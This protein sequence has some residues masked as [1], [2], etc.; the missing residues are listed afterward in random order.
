MTGTGTV[1]VIVQ[2]VNDH[3]PEFKRQA[4]RATIAEN[5]PSGTWVLTPVA[6]DKDAG[7]NAKIRYSLLGD[8]VDRFKINQDTG[9]ISTA[10]SLDREDT[11]TYHLTLI[12]QD[13]SPTEPRASTVNLTIEVTDE[14]DNSPTF[15]SSKFEIY[16]SDKTKVNQFVF[17][18]YAKDTDSGRNSQVAYRLVGEHSRF[19]R[20]N[21]ETG[22]IKVVQDLIKASTSV[23]NLEVEASDGGVKPRQTSAELTV[24]VKADYLFPRFSVP[25][26]T[27]FTLPEDAKEG[28]I[29]AKVK[30]TSPKKGIVGN[31]R[32]KCGRSSEDRQKHWG[33]TSVPQRF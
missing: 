29:I 13:C 27:H 19:F 2:D 5:S 24:F 9:F 17:G 28:R 7:L 16:I 6:M 33:S 32:W 30:A 4:Y 20:I 21:P 14:N 23:F 1:R 31:I 18:A 8:K 15:T 25:S 11:A 22:V 3:T 10:V 12:A 26:K